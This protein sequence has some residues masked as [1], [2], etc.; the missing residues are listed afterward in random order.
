MVD[1]QC[2]FSDGHESTQTNTF[3]AVSVARQSTQVDIQL[4]ANALHLHS[5][6]RTMMHMDYDEEI[7]ASQE[8]HVEVCL[9]IYN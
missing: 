4:E 3:P 8:D 1:K 5:D 9:Y 7:M 6:K 2:W